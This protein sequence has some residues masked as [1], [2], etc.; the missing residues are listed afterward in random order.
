MCALKWKEPLA[1]AE[2]MQIN[3]DRLSVWNDF[4]RQLGDDTDPLACGI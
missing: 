2:Y 3:L 1:C 4:S